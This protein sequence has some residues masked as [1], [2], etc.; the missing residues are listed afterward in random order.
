MILGWT[1]WYCEFCLASDWMIF[2]L[3]ILILWILCGVGLNDIWVEHLPNFPGLAQR[4]STFQCWHI[5]ATLL[6]LSSSHYQ[7]QYE[8]FHSKS[9]APST[10]FEMRNLHLISMWYIPCNSFWWVCLFF[11]IF[12]NSG[13]KF[14]WRSPCPCLALTIAPTE[15]IQIFLFSLHGRCV[16]FLP[17]KNNLLKEEIQIHAR[18]EYIHNWN[19]GII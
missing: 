17:N 10:K 11:S 13:Q 18:Y 8:I 6:L 2:V 12:L 5:S 15:I 3:N 4:L 1:S 7:N 16:S 9:L 19:N 14:S